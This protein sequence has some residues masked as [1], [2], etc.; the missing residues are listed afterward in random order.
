MLFPSASMTP[1]SLLLPLWP[2]LLRHSVKSSSS[3]H[4]SHHLPLGFVCDPFLFSVN[5]HLHASVSQASFLMS[6]QTSL[7]GCP[8]GLSDS[9]WPK[10]TPSTFPQTYCFSSCNPISG[11]CRHHCPSSC[12]SHRLHVI[13]HCLSHPHPISHQ[14]LSSL[15]PAPLSNPSSCLPLHSLGSSTISLF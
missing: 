3:S 4:P 5:Y 12:S 1:S 6:D 9:A 11:N 13:T 7:F 15:P 2:L 8:T 14:V 10:C